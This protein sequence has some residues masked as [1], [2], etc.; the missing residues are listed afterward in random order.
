MRNALADWISAHGLTGV[1]AHDVELATY[2]ALINTASHAYSAGVAG[3]VELHAHHQDDLIRITVT[4]HGRWQPPT[5]DPGQLRGRGLTLIRALADH[6]IL[7]PTDV[8]TTV[9][10][11]WYLTLPETLDTS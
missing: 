9:T 11:T 8:G 3:T 10:M 1:L 2:E 6:T 4:D 7:A 5:T